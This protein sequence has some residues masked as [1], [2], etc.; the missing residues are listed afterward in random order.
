V[1][2]L[3]YTPRV[4]VSRLSLYDQLATFEIF[5]IFAKLH[6]VSGPHESG[7]F[8]SAGPEDPT[9]EPNV[10]WIG[11][12][13]AKL[14]LF[15]IFRSVSSISKWMPRWVPTADQINSINLIKRSATG[16]TSGRGGWHRS[17]NPTRLFLTVKKSRV[18]CV[19]WSI[20]LYSIQSNRVQIE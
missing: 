14:W 18:R 20:K 11:W 15:E 2:N 1:A 13:L 12:P 9:L 10:K 8:W 17:G 19:G 4:L 6:L 3:T 5:K 16:L 7:T